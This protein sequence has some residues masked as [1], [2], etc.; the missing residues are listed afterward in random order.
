VGCGELGGPLTGAREAM[1]RE[2]VVRAAAVGTPV[3]SE[4]RLGE[5]GVR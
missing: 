2:T 1:R 3:R 5:M 4:L